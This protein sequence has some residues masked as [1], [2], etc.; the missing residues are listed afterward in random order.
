LAQQQKKETKMSTRANIIIKDKYSELIFYRSCDGCPDCCG[1]SLEHFCQLGRQ[2][3]IRDH[4]VQASGWLIILG[5]AEYK[6]VSPKCFE[7]ERF[8]FSEIEPLNWKCG[9]FEPTDSIHFDIEY[10]YVVDLTT[11]TVHIDGVDG[12]KYKGKYSRKG[13]DIL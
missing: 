13:V 7:G 3:K 8:E 6:S 2:K 4:L 1:K 11:W 10:L 9:A 12:F 5:A